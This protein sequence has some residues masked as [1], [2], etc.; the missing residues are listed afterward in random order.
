MTVAGCLVSLATL[1]G[2]MMYP[3]PTGAIDAVH[4]VLQTNVHEQDSFWLIQKYPSSTAVEHYQRVFAGWRNCYGPER[5]WWSFGD[6]STGEDRFIHQLLRHW[7]N[8][9][10]DTAVTVVLRYSSSGIEDRA[11]PDNERQFVVVL[12]HRQPDAEKYLNDN[13]VQCEKAPNNAL[14]QTRDE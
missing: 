12:R 10:N 9:A 13:E 11:V 1:G 7:L 14:E 8:A 2:S 3:V 6:H 5:E 4:D